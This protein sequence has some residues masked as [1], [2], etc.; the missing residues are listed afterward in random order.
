MAILEDPKTFK[1]IQTE[2]NHLFTRDRVRDDDCGYVWH[3]RCLLKYAPKIRSLLDNAC[4]GGDFLRQFQALSPATRLTGTDISNEAIRIAKKECPAATYI[5]SVGES[6]SFQKASFDAIT[7][8]GSLEH[9]LDIKKAIGEM[10]QVIRP[11]GILYI[12][13]PNLFWYKDILSV[14]FTGDK[15]D[16]N[17]TQERFASL[18]EWRRTLEEAGLQIKAVE[19][20][21]GVAKYAFKQ[22]L[23]DLLVPLKFSYHFVFICQKK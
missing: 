20:Y 12:L 22:W 3:A 8:L 17:Q 7:C 13:V 14:L 18:G 9:F 1:D 19:K 10:L 23:K 2:Y 15:K 6:L 11:D 5:L 21:N 16:R 4:G